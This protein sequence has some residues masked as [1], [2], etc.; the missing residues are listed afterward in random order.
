MMIKVS[1]KQKE[2][3]GKETNVFPDKNYLLSLKTEML[4]DTQT[5]NKGSGEAKKNQK[6]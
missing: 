2:R 1:V 5:G 3:S 6:G 4:H